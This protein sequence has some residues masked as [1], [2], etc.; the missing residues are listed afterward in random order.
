MLFRSGL[1]G[2]LHL[3]VGQPLGPLEVLDPAEAVVPP[4]IA[5]AAALE[6]PRQPLAAVEDHV[7]IEGEPGLEPHLGQPEA[8]VEGVD[9]VVQA[10]AR[11]AAQL[12][13]VGLGVAV[14]VIGGAVLQ[15]A[16][17]TDQP[18]RGGAVTLEAA[19]DQG[20]LVGVTGEVLDRPP[21]L[22]RLGL[23]R[24]AELL[25]ALL[26]GGGEVLEGDASGLEPAGEAAG[27][28]QAR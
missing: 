10:L 22:L 23:D 27:V 16:E 3:A 11:A 25:G 1:P 6:V 13:R 26:R 19:A 9:V 14:D 17:G 2:D 24:L 18:A 21:G 20:L 8:A 5:D 28:G 7:G 12:D 4:L 15:G